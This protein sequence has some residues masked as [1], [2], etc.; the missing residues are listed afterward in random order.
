MIDKN[1]YQD[2]I[3]QQV[4]S[5]GLSM[6]KTTVGI[7]DWAS[8]MI[9]MELEM[10]SELKHLELQESGIYIKHIVGCHKNINNSCLEIPYFSYCKLFL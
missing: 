3:Y 6:N 8:A 1:L 2:L 4:Y 10:E 9:Q 5:K 7:Q